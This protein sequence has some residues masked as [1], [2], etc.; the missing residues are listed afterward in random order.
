M[1]A[2]ITASRYLG[3]NEAELPPK[4]NGH[5]KALHTLVTCVDTLLSRVL[6]DT[7]F[8]F[9]VMPKNRFSQLQVGGRDESQCIG[10]ESL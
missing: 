3:F 10:Y 9:N 6:V 5:N 7:G 2:N 8:S 1:V 4:G